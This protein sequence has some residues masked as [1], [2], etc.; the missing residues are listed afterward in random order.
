MGCHLCG[1]KLDARP[2]GPGG[3]RQLEDA[4]AALLAEIND[5]DRVLVPRVLVDRLQRRHKPLTAAVCLCQKLHFDGELGERLEH[6]LAGCDA[7]RGRESE[8]AELVLVHDLPVDDKVADVAPAY[9]VAA[10]AQPFGALVDEDGLPGERVPEICSAEG[11]LGDGGPGAVDHLHRLLDCLRCEL[12][13]DGRGAVREHDADGRVDHAGLFGAQLDDDL[14]RG[15]LAR[16]DGAQRVSSQFHCICRGT[17]GLA[18][19]V[20]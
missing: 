13:A 7:H 18:M 16:P 15:L 17:C 1:V 11:E 2:D 8:A 4:E 20:L 19:P 6:P 14:A 10:E 12:H 5:E 3:Q 9:D